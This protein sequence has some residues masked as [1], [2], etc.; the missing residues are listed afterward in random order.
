M[1]TKFVMRLGGLLPTMHTSMLYWR[2]R[3]WTV[4]MYMYAGKLAMLLFFMYMIVNKLKL[5]IKCFVLRH[6]AMKIFPH[7]SPLRNNKYKNFN[8][9]VS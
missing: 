4:H 9:F 6:T 8:L 2:N 1:N 7:H 3:V 5:N